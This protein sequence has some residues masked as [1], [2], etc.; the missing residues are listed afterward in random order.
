[1]MVLLIVLLVGANLC[2]CSLFSEESENGDSDPVD[3]EEITLVLYFGGPD[4]E[5]LVLEER[6]VIANAEPAVLVVQEL[7][8]GPVSD[9]LLATIPDGTQLLHLSIAEGTAQVDFS[10]E[11]ITRHPGGSTGEMLTIYSI[12][13]SLTELPGIVQVQLLVQGEIVE[14]L[15]GHIE[16]SEPIERN[17]QIIQH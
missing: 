14:T 17:S 10:E 13:N 8:H 5:G 6:T 9:E 3:D 12:V 11:M 1:M 16:I 15:A 4:A 2:G 7:I